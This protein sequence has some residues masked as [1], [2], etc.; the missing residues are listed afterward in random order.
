MIEGQFT[1][2]KQYC[3]MIHFHSKS[4]LILESYYSQSKKYFAERG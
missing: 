4:Y 2:T 1:L 3:N